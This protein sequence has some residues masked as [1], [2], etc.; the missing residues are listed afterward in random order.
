MGDIV[1]HAC[2]EPHKTREKVSE[3]FVGEMEE[4]SWLYSS[5]P[6]NNLDICWWGNMAE[7]SN[8]ETSKICWW[9]FLDGA[10]RHTLPD[11]SLSDKEGRGRDVKINGSLLILQQPS[12]CGAQNPERSEKVRLYSHNTVPQERRIQHVQRSLVESHRR[13]PWKV[14]GKLGKAS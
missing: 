7:S 3:A 8:Q 9:Q 12:D 11:L 14:K 10:E 4:A 2:Y 5:G 1:V 13:L 6:T